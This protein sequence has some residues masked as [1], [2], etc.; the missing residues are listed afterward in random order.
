MNGF[1][2]RTAVITGVS[3]GIGLAIRKQFE[4]QGAKVYGID[5]QG[6]NCFIG[7]IS[8]KQTLED[9]VSYVLSEEE[10]IDFLINN[11][12]PRKFGISSC[13]YEDFE[14]ALRTG[15]IAP[16]Y[17]SKLLMDR[18]SKDGCIVNISSTRD[19]QSQ[20]E[21]E[22]YAAAK[23]GIRALTHSLAVSL[24]GKVRVNS[25]SPGWIDTEYRRYEGSDADQHLV[26]R[27]GDPD[28][29]ANAVLFLCSDKASFIDG[30]NI[31]IDGGM[32]KLMI[33]HDD[34]NWKLEEK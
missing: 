33:Y 24:Q 2:N 7:D 19:S 4:A 27:V 21:S 15:V 30:E 13:S 26:K 28:D 11:A 34:Y 14:N 32:S 18:F 31:V 22:S 20:T 8:N 3:H 6:E 1:K 9:F 17:L 5:L 29:I 25:V 23:G 16:F 10:Q 12:P